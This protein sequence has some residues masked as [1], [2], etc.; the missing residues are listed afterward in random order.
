MTVLHSRT[1]GRTALGHWTLNN[2]QPTVQ[3]SDCLAPLDRREQTLNNLERD[4]PEGA[5]PVGTTGADD[6][7]RDTARREQIRELR[8]QSDSLRRTLKDQER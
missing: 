3:T 2:Q 6:D 8:Q 4:E 7:S 5:A 1:R